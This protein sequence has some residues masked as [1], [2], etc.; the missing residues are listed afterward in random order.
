VG[1]GD[2]AVD[3]SW[4]LWPITF[5]SISRHAVSG[6]QAKNQVVEHISPTGYVTTPLKKQG[7]TLFV[8][9]ISDAPLLG[10]GLFPLS[11]SGGDSEDLVRSLLVN[12]VKVG[13]MYDMDLIINAAMPGV[14]FRQTAQT[15][16]S[17]PSKTG[18]QYFGLENQN[19]FWD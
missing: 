6:K 7:D 2:P 1:H 13:A 12:R 5:A 8:G 11:V 4:S 3:I 17:I 19:G 18:H 10:K 9:Q 14:H 16:A 15:P